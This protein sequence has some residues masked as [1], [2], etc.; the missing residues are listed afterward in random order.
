MT[1]QEARIFKRLIR[2][3]VDVEGKCKMFSLGDGCMCPLCQVDRMDPE[4][5]RAATERVIQENCEYR[6]FISDAIGLWSN[7]IPSFMGKKGTFLKEDENEQI[8]TPKTRYELLKE[9]ENG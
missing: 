8:N 1:E 2:E 5:V 3:N 9:T 7:S 6:P 4:K